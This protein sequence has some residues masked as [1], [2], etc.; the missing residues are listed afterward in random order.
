M[1][2]YFVE[3]IITLP[4]MA[5]WWVS[6]GFLDTSRMLPAQLHSANCKIWCKRDNVFFFSWVGLGSLLPVKGNLNA[7]PYQDIL[8]NA[9]LA[10][11]QKQYGKVPFIFQHDCAPVQWAR[12]I[13]TWLDEFGGKE[14]DLTLDTFGMNWNEDCEPGLLV[15]HQCLTSQ[16]LY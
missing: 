6:L 16:I 10:A 11:L 7:S 1:G 9:M 8:D 15:Q 3:W 4:C 13:K 12:S 2:T 5:V 14:L